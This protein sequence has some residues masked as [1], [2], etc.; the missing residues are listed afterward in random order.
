MEQQSREN[1]KTR[2][3]IEIQRLKL[4]GSI[5]YE[6]VS[7]QP[8]DNNHENGFDILSFTEDGQ[9][10]YIEVKTTPAD[11]K[12]AFYISK[13]EYNKAQDV[14][15]SGGIYKIHRVYNI[16][17]EYDKIGYEIY[18]SLD[19]DKFIFEEIAYKVT[20]KKQIKNMMS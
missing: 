17:D 6:K 18:N 8:A 4:A 10:I 12:Q 20:F 2:R 9:E 16:F 15:K 14:W 7:N 3:K 19:Y 5:Y 11:L 13:N 1:W